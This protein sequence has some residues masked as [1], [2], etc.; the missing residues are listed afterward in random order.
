MSQDTCSVLY[1]YFF[2]HACIERRNTAQFGT[3]LDIW[4][5][6]GQQQVIRRPFDP[7]YSLVN[8]HG[9]LRYF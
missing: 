6:G 3:V 1:T 9:R 2:L 5:V 4:Y 7:Y 8:V